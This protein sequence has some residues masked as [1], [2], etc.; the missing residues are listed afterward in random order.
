MKWA[1]A[2]FLRA[3]LVDKG[4]SS[5]N[6][7]LKFYK[8]QCKVLEKATKDLKITYLSPPMQSSDENGYLLPDYCAN[9][10]THANANYDA[11]LL[12]QI[13]SLIVSCEIN[14]A[15]QTY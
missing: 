5:S 6:L 4:V 8:L 2:T 10:A 12:S 15:V 7:R 11:L 3:G 9:D 14:D 13:E 1:G